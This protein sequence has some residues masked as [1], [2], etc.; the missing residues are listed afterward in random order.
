MRRSLLPLALCFLPP[1]ATAGQLTLSPSFL[2]VD[3]GVHSALV[4]VAY[5]PGAGVT[6]LEAELA[7]PL[8][9]AGWVEAQVV[10]AG[11]AAHENFCQIVGGRV[12][13][14]LSSR[15]LEPL[16]TGQ[17]I[18]LCTVRIRTHSFTPRMH[19][20]I[21]P[22]NVYEYSASGRVGFASTNNVRVVVP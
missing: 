16:P 8:E 12:R 6:D 2:S 5:W 10:P 7:L 15:N 4:T 9:R 1:L 11:T 22:S 14:I 13:T 3:N 19:Y 17:A 18:P 20:E 21:T